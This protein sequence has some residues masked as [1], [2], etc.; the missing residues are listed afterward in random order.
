MEIVGVGESVERSGAS[1]VGPVGPELGRFLDYIATAE[2][3][4]W[5]AGELF[6][7]AASGALEVSIH[8]EYPLADAA[9]AQR[10]LE[11]GTTA[12]K[13]LLTV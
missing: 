5:R 10:D 4:A 9:Q 1:V 12:G 11:S 2:E 6:D 3:L 8:A 7:L 13:L